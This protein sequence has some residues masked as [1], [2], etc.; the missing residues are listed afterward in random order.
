MKK[1][2]SHI[3]EH[4][5]Q[6]SNGLKETSGDGSCLAFD[7]K[8]GIMFNAYMPG[9]QGNYG[10]SRGRIAL[11]YFPATQPT[12][13]RFAVVSEG[14]D[15]YCNNIFGLG[16]GRVR[17]F[18]EKNSR[19]EGDHLYCYKDFDFL[20]ESFSEEKALMVKTEEGE[21]TPL[22]LSLQFKYLEKRGLFAH[23]YRKTEQTGHCEFFKGE[24]GFIYGAT[25]SFL[26][27]VILFRSRDGL[28]SV[29]LFAVFPKSCQ[30]EFEYRIIKG[31]IY[32]LCRTNS[33]RDSIT[34]YTS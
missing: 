17:I 30:S 4:S 22:T 11:S 32:A 25:V 27:E 7:S 12:N 28:E 21:Y 33:E 9:R 15:V 24:D 23:E 6:I 16:D 31:R 34:Y 18:Y 14:D 8:Y 20:S 1:D 13:I 2:L 3:L 5:V 29:E 26:S 19:E 10:E